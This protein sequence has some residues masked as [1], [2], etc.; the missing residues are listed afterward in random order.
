MSLSTERL[1]FWLLLV[2][3]VL[4]AVLLFLGPEDLLGDVNTTQYALKTLL[5]PSIL[6]WLIF[7]WRLIDKKINNGKPG[8]SD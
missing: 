4:G 6:A 1:L 3:S 7:A 8:E 5:Y 2:L